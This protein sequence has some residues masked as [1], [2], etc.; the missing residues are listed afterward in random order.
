M[1]GQLEINPPFF[2]LWKKGALN[3]L[4]FKG[5]LYVFGLNILEHIPLSSS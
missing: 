5:Q 3:P 4:L 2:A 1:E